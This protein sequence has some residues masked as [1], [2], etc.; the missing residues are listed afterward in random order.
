MKKLIAILLALTMCVAL[1]AACD[2]EITPAEEP[3]ATEEPTVDDPAPAPADDEIPDTPPG[4]LEELGLDENRRFIEQRTITVQA[5]ERDESP[6]GTVFTDYIIEGMLNEHNV[7]VEFVGTGRWQDPDEIT[8]MLAEGTAPDVCYTFNYPT[9]ENFGLQGLDA[10]GNEIEGRTTIWDLEQFLNDSGDVFPN[11]WERLGRSLLYWNQDAETGRIW[12]ILGK[13]AFN[14]RYIPF[15]REDWLAELDLPLPTNV[16]EFEDSLIAFRDNADTLL[17]SDARQMIPLHMTDD[18]GWL[19]GVMAGAY[20]PDN[21]T[22]REFYI[23]DVGGARNFFQPG[24]KEAVRVLNKWFNEGLMHPDFALFTTGDD[25]PDNLVRAGFVGA[26]A[27]HSWDQ[28]YRGGDEGW[29]G[30]MHAAQSTDANFI[31][32]D[33]FLNDAGQYRK[34]LGGGQDRTLFVPASSTEPVAALM[35]LDFLSRAETTIFLQVGVEGIN[36]EVQENGALMNLPVAP[37]DP[38]HM[39]SGMN[40]DL[41][42]PTNGLDLNDLHLTTIS[43]AVGYAGIESRLIEAAVAV[44]MNGVRI[45]GNVDA[46]TIAAEEGMGDTIRERG[47]AA[48]ARAIVAPVD[49]FDAVYDSEMADLLSN[50]AQAAID[51]RTAAWEARWGSATMLPTD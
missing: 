41:T 2:P 9:V 29:T 31:A 34:Y 40:Y 46:G 16:Q 17:G 7:V 22:D 48:W 36:H 35:Y 44:Q 43:R 37:G 25:A 42:M 33:T 4:R 6:I 51:E 8:I 24:V 3:P 18:V 20:M 19:I 50:F 39:S 10:D 12:A 27:S 28:P 26:I 32:V 23:H 30:L 14:Q 15:I 45:I 5:W 47:N 13:Q 38:H 11:L 49:Q 21:I 1:V